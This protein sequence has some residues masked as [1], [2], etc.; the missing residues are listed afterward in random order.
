MAHGQPTG[1]L[2]VSFVAVLAGILSLALLLT[3]VSQVWFKE[4]NDY[5]SIRYKPLSLHICAHYRSATVCTAEIEWHDAALTTTRGLDY[6]VHEVVQNTIIASGACPVAI[7]LEPCITAI[8]TNHFGYTPVSGYELKH[9]VDRVSAIM[10]LVLIYPL[11]VFALLLLLG[12]HALREWPILT[13]RG[14]VNVPP[15]TWETLA[16]GLI[17]LGLLISS[18]VAL[19]SWQIGGIHIESGGI[20]GSTGTLMYFVTV[21][22]LI[23]QWRMF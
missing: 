7:M 13:A 5:L 19:F 15:W 17:T 2:V 21:C 11:A 12:Y 3:S 10:G 14:T 22:I 6:Q 1:R 16:V 4:S 23:I 18:S 9:T 8:A 20:E